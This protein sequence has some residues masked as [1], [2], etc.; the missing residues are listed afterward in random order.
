MTCDEGIFRVARE[1]QLIRQEEFKDIVL[2]LGSFHMTKIALGCL[3]KY[4]KGSGTENILIES[5]VFGI[6]V[7]HSVLSGKS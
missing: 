3:E 4:L 6:N 2:C 1:I 7:I 5:A